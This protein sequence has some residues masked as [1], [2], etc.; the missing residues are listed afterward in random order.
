[1][2]VFTTLALPSDEWFPRGLTIGS[3]DGVHLGHQMILSR[4]RQ[5][6][7][8]EGGVAVIS[9][10]NH[11]SELFRGKSVPLLSSKEQK[12]KLLEEQ[13]VDVL[14]LLAFDQDLAGQSYHAFLH[15][16]KEVYPFTH[17]IHGKGDAFGRNREGDETHILAMAQKEDFSAEYVDK[18]YPEG[19]PLSSGVIRELIAEARFSEAAFLLGR[20]YSLMAPLEINVQ[21]PHEAQMATGML[22]LPP[23]GSY[24]CEIFWNGKHL[25]T[26][27]IVFQ[28]A[29]RV[30]LRFPHALYPERGRIAELVFH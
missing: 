1:M 21:D 10:S 28:A 19:K 6:V 26:Q 2:E 11:P 16:V 23:D 5:R 18:F 13:G 27:A 8:P 30:V 22:C 17:L 14:Y 4:L 3:F 29:Q 9:F 24:A 12:I 25:P 7:G 15:E 20:P